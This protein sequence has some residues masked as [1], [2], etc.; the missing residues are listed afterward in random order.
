MNWSPETLAKPDTSTLEEI[1]DLKDEG[2]KE[3]LRELYQQLL[4]DGPLHVGELVHAMQ[5]GELDEVD[6]ISHRLKSSFGNLGFVAASALCN[7]IMRSARAGELDEAEEFVQHLEE[8]GEALVR[9]IATFLTT[10]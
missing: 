1:F 3:V 7:E 9:G 6:R 10:L 2:D 8:A 5:K 4:E